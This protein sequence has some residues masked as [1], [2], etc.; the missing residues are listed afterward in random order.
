MERIAEGQVISEMRD[1]RRYNQ[2]MSGR[3]VQHE[4]RALARQVAD[5]GVPSGGRV[6]DVGTGPGFVALLVAQL[7]P[8]AQ[9]V[10][11]DLSTAMLT[12]AAENAQQKGLNGRLSWREGDA[13][14]M[15]FADD[16][17]DFVVSSGSLHHWEEPLLVLDEAARV[18]KP[19]GGCIIRDSK[20][21]Q[22]WAPRLA[23]GAIGLMIPRD[24]RVHYWASIRSSYTPRELRRLLEQSRLQGW[25][26][27]EDF[28][29]L[30]IVKGR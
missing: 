28:M 30:A 7:L 8:D 2:V 27:V 9:V 4:Y 15:P 13:K 23:A 10:G 12:V 18:L 5:M 16:E 1:A 29:D 21:L 22:S 3:M 24:F 20:R 6:L 26:I 14:A 19:N 25:E 17:F 11:L